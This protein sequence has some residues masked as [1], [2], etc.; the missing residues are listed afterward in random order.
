[1]KI[2]PRSPISERAARAF[3][4]TRREREGRGAIGRKLGKRFQQTGDDGQP[5]HEVPGREVENRELDRGPDLA[6]QVGQ[7]DTSPICH[8][9]CWLR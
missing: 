6:T 2:R 3:G 8:G 5:I 4:G 7:I 1:M 9:W